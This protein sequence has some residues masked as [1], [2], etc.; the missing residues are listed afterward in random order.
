[1]EGVSHPRA[2]RCRADQEDGPRSPRSGSCCRCLAATRVGGQL[3]RLLRP[4]GWGEG[5]RPT[6]S[7]EAGSPP[8]GR[9]PAP[10]RKAPR[11]KAS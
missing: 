6:P 1:M 8:R 3:G 7:R 10:Y 5:G 2:L 11:T 4:S 9:L